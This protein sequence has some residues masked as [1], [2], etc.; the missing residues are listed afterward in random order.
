MDKETGNFCLSGKS[1]P[2]SNKRDS[3]TY[4]KKLGSVG[5]DEHGVSN[6]GELNN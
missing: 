3:S 5:R 4:D 6:R 2:F 1:K